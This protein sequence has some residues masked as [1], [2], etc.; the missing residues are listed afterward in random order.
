VSLDL[1]GLDPSHVNQCA[2]CQHAIRIARVVEH[3]H[4]S[5]YLFGGGGYGDALPRQFDADHCGCCRAVSGTLAYADRQTRMY[6]DMW[7]TAER[8]HA[9]AAGL[10]RAAIRLLP[11]SANRTAELQAEVEEQARQDAF[12]RR[13]IERITA[14]RDVLL[15]GLESILWALEGGPA[16]P[17]YDRYIAKLDPTDPVT[18]IRKVLHRTF[19]AAIAALHG[20]RKPPARRRSARP[21]AAFTT[22]QAALDLEGGE[23]A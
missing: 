1:Y 10:L 11:C 16:D 20:D 19:D 15:A 14:Q 21:A 3:R 4:L 7:R 9:R 13:E 5:R 22:G 6:V 23:A 17:V 2:C 12:Q 18:G 8:S